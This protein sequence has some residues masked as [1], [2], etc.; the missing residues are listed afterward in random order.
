MKRRQFLAAFSTLTISGCAE[1]SSRPT[2]S[3]TPESSVTT[4]ESSS[5]VQRDEETKTS[6]RPQSTYRFASVYNG[7]NRTYQIS[8]KIIEVE[9]NNVYLKL[10]QKLKTDGQ[11]NIDDGW[12]KKEGKYRLTAETEEGMNTSLEVYAD[13]SWAC[14]HTVHVDITSE[15]RLASGLSSGMEKKC[16]NNN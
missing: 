13:E 12:L 3:P 9:T 8:V 7:H 11:F 10:N 15:G 6:T 1:R 5:T 2:S 4:A 16:E 14:S